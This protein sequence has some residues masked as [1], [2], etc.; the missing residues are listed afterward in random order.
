MLITVYAEDGH[1]DVENNIIDCEN[2]CNEDFTDVRFIDSGQTNVL[3]YWIE[4]IGIA[5]GE[6]YAQIWV[7][8]SGEESIYMYYGN[9]NAYSESEG[10]ETFIFF[11]DFLTFDTSIWDEYDP[12]DKVAVAFGEALTDGYKE[13]IAQSQLKMGY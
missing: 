13:Y 12:D 11:D 8:T 5:S 1:D 6:H 9:P 7:K 10:T 2:H 4:E 3:S